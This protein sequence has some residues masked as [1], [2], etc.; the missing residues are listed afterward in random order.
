MAGV[1]AADSSGGC[2]QTL[3]AFV[4][5]LAAVVTEVAVSSSSCCVVVAVK[6]VVALG[7]GSVVTVAVVAD[8]VAVAAGGECVRA[9]GSKEWR[10]GFRGPGERWL[11][12]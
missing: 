3:A 9:E 8:V 5:V 4:F 11:T 2:L 6:C 7:S 1:Q 12:E 10:R